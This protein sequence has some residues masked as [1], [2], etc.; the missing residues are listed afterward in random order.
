MLLDEG[1]IHPQQLRRKAG[2]KTFPFSKGWDELQADFKVL[3]TKVTEAGRGRYAYV[4]DCVHRHYPE[5]LQ[6]A[7][8]IG[9]L[10]ARAKILETYFSSVG[11]A[12]VGDINKLFGWEMV[13]TLEAI[14]ALVQYSF[15]VGREHPKPDSAFVLGELM[16][17]LSR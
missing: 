10:E 14:E 5:L 15:L 8:A 1:P 4:Y 3:A 9:S 7:V 16:K 2:L 11:A 13:E 12:L 17:E 6:Q